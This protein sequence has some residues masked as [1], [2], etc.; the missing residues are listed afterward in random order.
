MH[1]FS[2][3]QCCSS[4][5]YL[6]YFQFLFCTLKFLVYA[7][8]YLNR[9]KFVACSQSANLIQISSIKLY[10]Q[11]DKKTSILYKKSENATSIELN[12]DFYMC[13][14]TTFKMHLLII[15]TFILLLFSA[16]FTS[17][18]KKSLPVK[19]ISS[20]IITDQRKTYKHIHFLS[21]TH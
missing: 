13:K 17:H 19:Q 14:K 10:Q 16:L 2:I 1:I 5:V 8:Y 20:Y 4:V 12:L 18:I 11:T 6:L 3:A 7:I 9:P 15:V 21:H